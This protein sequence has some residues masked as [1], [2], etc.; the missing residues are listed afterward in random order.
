MNSDA[1][2]RRR[3]PE[4]GLCMVNYLLDSSAVIDILRNDP[5]A[6]KNMQVALKNKYV[7]SICPHVYYEVVRGFKGDINTNKF[8]TF[9][10]L[11]KS[12]KNLPFDMRA[13]NKAVEIYLHLRNG[14][15]IE[16]ND[17][18]IAAT[19]IVNDCVLVTANTRHF[20]RVKNLNFVNWRT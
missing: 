4:S 11:Y 7:L 20:S 17:I 5:A 10:T 2:K 18:F 13:S 6:K 3:K 16:D 9:L 19:A 14:Q 12:W 1:I 15:L 8:R